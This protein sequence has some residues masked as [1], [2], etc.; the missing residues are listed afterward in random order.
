MASSQGPELAA[1]A[2]APPRRDAAATA[3]YGG[4]DAARAGGHT[5]ADALDGAVTAIAAAGCET[6][7][8]DAE[9]LLAEVLGVGRERLLLDR[10]LTVA[11]PAVRAF[12]DAVRR[13]ALA[14]EPVAYILGRRGFRG[15]E[16]AVDSRVL[17]PRPETEL[18]VECALSLPAGA[19]VL[20]V[21][22]GSGA[23]ALALK[24][25]RPDLEVTASDLSKQALEVARANGL[26]LGLEVR[27]LRADLLAGVP[28]A[29]D[30]VLANLPYVS[31]GD[32]ATLAPE[33]ARHEPPQALFAGAGGLAAIAALLEQLQSLPSAGFLAL[34]VG[35][36]QAAAVGEMA[37]AAGFRTVRAERDLAG[38][39]RVVIAEEGAR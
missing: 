36:G 22:T 39:E 26:R 3:S 21:G 12:Q 35:A 37:R 17:I 8:L 7:R 20:D 31:E 4:R 28:N 38:V 27:W 24:D 6:P 34:E 2:G 5:I 30:A 23:V 15:I 14:R 11:G 1:D 19:R 10:G 9:L 29:F 18:L 32:R 16:L 25:E 33:I 13:R